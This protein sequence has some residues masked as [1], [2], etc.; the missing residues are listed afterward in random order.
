VYDP[1]RITTLGFVYYGSGR[2]NTSSI[3]DKSY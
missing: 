3:N 2:A 1:V